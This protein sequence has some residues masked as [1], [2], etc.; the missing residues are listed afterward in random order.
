M[1]LGRCFEFSVFSY[2]ITIM[3][4]VIIFIIVLGVLVFVHEFGHFIFSKRAGMKV[5]EFGFG[6]P[7][8]IWGIKKGETL[9]SINAIP[10]GGFVKILGEGGE[11]A[12]N[13]RSFSSKAIGPR[14]KVII[15]GVTMNFFLA[16]V[17]LMITNFFG[18]RIG[19][20]DDKTASLARDKQVQIIEVSKDS[21]ADKAGLKLLDEVSGFKV[22]GLLETV[23]NAE[24]VQA[25]IQKN[26]GKSLTIVINR[27][28]EILEKEIVPRVNP[29]VGQ[30]AL[31]VSLA[32]TGVVSYP[33]YEAMWRGV[34]DAVVLTM[35]TVIGYFVL[36]KTLL[37]EGKLIADV[38]GPVGIAT[39]TGQ[40]A[41]MG[42]NYL[43][44]FTAMISINLAVL[45]IIPFPALDGGRALLIIIEKLK[46]SPVNKKAEQLV[47]TVGFMFLIALMVYVTTKD[48][49]RFF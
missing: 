13:P 17:L 1:W 15:A 5:E 49:L 38:S 25:F 10:F 23:S 46:G 34:F 9:Y 4:T 41:R 40:A 7:P 27:N 11:E 6:F 14:L 3:I 26:T 2:R 42:I 45:N 22:N 32:L 16:V 39:L 19:L 20:I 36:F 43:M 28:E 48:I 29:P 12:N 35:N 21:P 18:L 30:G 44:Q 31:G 33:W 8:R 47:N 24:D 37:F